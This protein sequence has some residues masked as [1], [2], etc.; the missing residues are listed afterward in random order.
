MP[1]NNKGERTMA[2]TKTIISKKSDLKTE[3]VSQLFSDIKVD[4]PNMQKKIN[5]IITKAQK[6]INELDPYDNPC[7]HCHGGRC[8]QCGYGYNDNKIE[9]Y[10]KL[11]EWLICKTAKEE[12][13]KLKNISNPSVIMPDIFYD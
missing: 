2:E 9:D 5:E 7:C 13:D 12:I 3:T 1:D 4:D 6:D 8:E 11:K 10:R